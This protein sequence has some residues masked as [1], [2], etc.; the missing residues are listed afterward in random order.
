[1]SGLITRY[2]DLAQLALASYTD[3]TSLFGIPQ[4][5]QIPSASGVRDAILGGFP[6]PLANAFSGVA[7]SQRGF[8]VLSQ[9]TDPSGFSATLFERIEANIDGSHD[10][11][12]AIRGTEPTQVSDILTDINVALLGEVKKRGLGRFKILTQQVMNGLGW[13]VPVQNFPRPIIEQRLHTR[14]VSS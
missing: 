12:L 5:P 10:K 3:F 11:F 14:N 4:S 9:R 6:F 8:R 13:A 1:M 2:F 7:D